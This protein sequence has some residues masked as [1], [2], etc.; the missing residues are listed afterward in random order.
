MNRWCPETWRGDKALMGISGNTVVP[1]EEGG[2]D[3][4]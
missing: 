3:G 1:D 4:Q 2:G